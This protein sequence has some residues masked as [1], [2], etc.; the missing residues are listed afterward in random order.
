LKNS[1]PTFHSILLH[2]KKKKKKTGIFSESILRENDTHASLF[3]HQRGWRHEAIAAY[4]SLFAYNWSFWEVMMGVL[5]AVGIYRIGI[6]GMVSYV[7]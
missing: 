3:H 1:N 2:P 5:F 4:F 6:V 7:E